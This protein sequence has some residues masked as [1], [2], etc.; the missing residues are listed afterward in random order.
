MSLIVGIPLGI[1]IGVIFILVGHDDFAGENIN[2]EMQTIA[3]SVIALSASVALVI[4]FL[5]I[6]SQKDSRRWEVNKG[7]LLEL[8]KTL[9]DLMNQTSKLVDNEFCNNQGIPEE[10]KFI[11]DNSIY[12]KF[13]Q[14][15]SHT[16]DVY[17]AVLN[18][19][20]INAIDTYKKENALIT[21]G[22]EQDA[23]S[24]FEAY[25]AELAAQEKLQKALSQ[26]IK[27]CANI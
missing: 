13:N 1:I 17:S 7:I 5:S 9:S 25:D 15:L 10:H 2:I 14:H 6:K 23:L 4:N 8:S 11:P 20:I 19:Q 22:V 24:L 18:N 21:S 26:H 12:K 27:K 16:K 3:S